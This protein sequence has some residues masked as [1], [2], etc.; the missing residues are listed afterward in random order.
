MRSRPII[1]PDMPS[2]HPTALIG[3]QAKL[4]DDVIVGPYCIIEGPVTI[5]PG[6]VINAHSYLAGSTTIGSGCTIGP[7]AYIGLPPQHTGYKG[8][9]THLVIG[10]DVII[11]ETAT[12]HRAYSEGIEHATR[13]G[14]RSLLMAR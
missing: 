14:S 10:D 1:A 12:V 4:A 8:Q 13:I 9:E 7:A 2:I 6:T 11:R 3:P 5:G